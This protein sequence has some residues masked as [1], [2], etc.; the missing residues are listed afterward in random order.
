MK[1]I[2][3]SHLFFF[4]LFTKTIL[5]QNINGIVKLSDGKPAE[6]AAILL[7][8]AKDSS[9]AKGSLTDENGIFEFYAIEKG[10]YL[11]S[12]SYVGFSKYTGSL[13]EHSGSDLKLEEIVLSD[14]GTELTALNV[15]ARKPLI[16]VQADRTILNVEASVTSAGSNGFDLLRKAP[17]VV[18]DNN[19]NI[20]LRGKNGVVV[21]LDGKRTFLKPQDLANLLKSMNAADLELIEVITNPS[22]KYDASGNAG[23]INLKLKKNKN[24]GTNGSVN[25][26]TAYGLYPKNTVSLNLNNRNGKTNIYGNMSIGR[27]EYYNTMN[28]YR[29][30]NGKIFDFRQNQLSTNTPLNVKFGADYFLHPNHT[31]GVIANMNTNIGEKKWDSNSK[32]FI[33]NDGSSLIDSV[34]VAANNNRGTLMNAN[35]NANYRYAD[36]TGNMFSFDIDKGLYRTDNNSF[37]PNL[38]QDA[39]LS[40]T[41]VDRTFKTQTPSKIDIFTLK[42]D[43]EKKIGKAGSVVSI[44]AKYA[45]VVTDNSF[46]FYNVINGQQIKD[47]YASNQFSYTENVAAAYI[48]G[49]IP[50]NKKASLQAGLRM[51]NTLSIGDLQRDPAF[52]SNSEDYV[53]RQYTNLFPSAAFTYSLNSKNSLNFSYSRRIDRPNYQDL[54]PFE[55]R[56]DE[57]S[58]RKG[59]PFLRPQYANNFEAKYIFMGFASI[60]GSYAK[61]RDLI[62]DIVEKDPLHP[63]KSYIKYRNLASQETYAVTISSPTP[64]KKWWNGYVNVSLSKAIYVANF[65]EYTFRTQTPIAVNLFAEQTFTLGKGFIFEMSGRFT[66]ASIWGGAWAVKPQGGLDLGLQKKILKEKATVKIA[67][68]DIFFTQPW[69]S[70]NTAIPGFKTYGNGTWES[71][72]VKLNFNYAFG[73]KSVKSARKRSIGLED[74]KRRIGG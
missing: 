51:E 27:S 3:I 54:N 69:R 16:E 19:D 10:S 20:Q 38:Y 42:A 35:F 36:K 48:N 62:S 8:N 59:S 26:N 63:N 30:Q 23:I 73:N 56:L 61:T 45:N 70:S 12:I 31:V 37:Q 72:Q 74:E 49:M 7:L 9:L 14:A 18:I 46:E 64:I 32:T 71:R 43:F 11:L 39:T 60:G 33:S 25:F 55:W 50:F 24:F 53:K 13:I 15:L 52:P 41:L 6:F 1:I 68:S 40:R 17:G 5:A 28:L 58:I 67:C 57:L 2:R 22:A 29:L 44:G 34:L 4:F 66:S 47:I 65:P 21:M